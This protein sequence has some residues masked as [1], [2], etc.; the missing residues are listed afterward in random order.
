MKTRLT[1]LLALL[2]VVCK[3]P[4][5]ADPL[6][7]YDTENGHFYTQANGRPLEQSPEGF[8]I[9]DDD[10]VFFWRDYLWFGGVQVLGYP[11]SRRFEWD[12]FVCQATQRAILQWDAGARQARLANVL[13]Q[14]SALGRDNWL[15]EARLVPRPLDQS[16]EKGMSPAQVTARRLSLLD[17]NPAM[18][19]AYYA[20]PEPLALYGLPTSEATDVGQAYAIRTQ[21]GVIYRWKDAVPWAGANQVSVGNAGELFKEAGFL[22]AEA[23][24]PESPPA[25]RRPVLSGRGSGRDVAPVEGVATWYGADFQGRLMTN[26][27]PYNMH[28]PTTT[29]SNAHPIGSLLRVTYLTSGAYV[30]VR[31]TDRGAF[32]YPIVVDL[33]YAAFSRLADPRRGTIPVRVEPV[34]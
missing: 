15:R 27:E 10:G 17:A 7:D 9:S 3:L 22:P 12:G 34:R 2:L 23:T 31:V 25:P 32:R 8:Q 1:L 11:I 6:L 13:D 30:I 14:M 24:V 21:R 4:A 28:D 5:S 18:R 29:A 20:A 16:V 19:A 26:R 33:S